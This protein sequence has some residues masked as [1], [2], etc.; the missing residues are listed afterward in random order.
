MVIYHYDRSGIFL[1]AG[2]AR[3]SPRGGFHPDGSAKEWLIPA[4]ATD[5]PPPAIGP[6]EVAVFDPAAKAW[7][8]REDHRGK[9]VWNTQTLMREMIVDLGPLPEGYT[10][11]APQDRFQKWEDGRWVVDLD[12]AAL[13]AR[14]E[15]NAKLASTDWTQMPDVPLTAEAKSAWATYR[16]ALRDYME[17]WAPGKPW[18]VEP[19]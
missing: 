2:E 10:T 1:C 13:Q 4:N 16:Q 17:N 12:K 14:F 19:E 5:V 7:S 18:P 9:S 15:R 8:K 6:D 3:P 11:V